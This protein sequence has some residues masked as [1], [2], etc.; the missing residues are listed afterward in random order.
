MIVN[1]NQDSDSLSFF[2]L[3]VYCFLVRLLPHVHNANCRL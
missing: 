2:V 1:F 3:L